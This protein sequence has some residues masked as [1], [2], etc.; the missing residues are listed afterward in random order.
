MPSDFDIPTP[1]SIIDSNKNKLSLQT[2]LLGNK[3]NFSNKSS[4]SKGVQLKSASG[5][6]QIK[7][8]VHNKQLAV[9]L[10]KKN[11]EKNFVFSGQNSP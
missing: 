3:N 2:T 5:D 10:V 11:Y 4:I 6:S 8:H 1:A 9:S 7:L